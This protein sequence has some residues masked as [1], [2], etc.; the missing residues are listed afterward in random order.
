SITTPTAGTPDVPLRL[1]PV[2]VMFNC[3]PGNPVLGRNPVINGRVSVPVSARV[4]A[5]DGAFVEVPPV[6]IVRLLIIRSGTMTTT[7]RGP[8]RAPAPTATTAWRPTTSLLESRTSVMPVA[9]SLESSTG[10]VEPGSKN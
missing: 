10:P 7:T 2:I 1:V 9:E 4:F 6:A 3:C 8:G 5:E